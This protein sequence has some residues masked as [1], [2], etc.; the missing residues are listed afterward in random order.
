MSDKA[1][2]VIRVVILLAVVYGAQSSSTA[3]EQG[4]RPFCFFYCAG[5]R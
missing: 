4:V 3:D 1:H 2:W 5:G